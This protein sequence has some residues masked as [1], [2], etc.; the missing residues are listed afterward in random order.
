MRSIA[1]NDSTSPRYGFSFSWEGSYGHVVE[2]V[3]RLGPERGVIIDLG[4]GVGS[5]AQPLLDLGY[6]YVGVDI[7]PVAL[8]ELSKRGLEGH[9]LDLCR[10]DELAKK[11]LDLA[12]GRR[13]ATVLLIDVLEHIPQT[14][15]FLAAIRAGLELLNRPPLVISVPN[16]AH[17]DL[18]AKLVFGKWDY[19]RTGLLDSTHMQFFTCDRLQSETRANGLLEL[20]AH[21]FKMRASDQHFP[22]D[23]PA[24][25]WTSPVAQAIRTWRE[26][27]DEHGETNQ[28][29]RAFAP[30]DIEPGQTPEIHPDV[31]ISTPLAVVMR[32]QGKRMS[33]LRDALTCLAAQTSDGFEVLLMVHT[34]DAQPVVGEVEALVSDFNPLFSSRVRVVHVS[35]GRRARPLNAALAR[36]KAEYVAFLD[37]DDL[38]MADWVE[39][40]V[41]AAGGGA[42]VRSGVA[43]REVSAPEESHCHPHVV[44]SALQFRYKLD[45][46]RLGHY[47]GNETPICSF[48]VPHSLIETLGLRFGEDLPV[49]EDWD[50]LMRCVAFASVRDTRKV[51]SIY[52]MWRSGESS[53]SLHE[54]DVWQATQRVLQDR[55]NLQSLILPPGSTD[56]LVRMCEQLVELDTLRLQLESARHEVATVRNNAQRDHE[57]IAAEVSAARDELQRI[58]SAYQM[59]INSRRWRILGPPARLIAVLRQAHLRLWSRARG[60]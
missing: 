24:L 36:V 4:C 13:V 32:T 42:I 10:T 23:H 59:T 54:V 7:D 52:Q 12:D 11:M 15:P 16:V 28:F 47:W 55:M 22:P 50:F 38:V 27:A 14:Q 48:A 43:V 17:S 39:S 56:R 40:F 60:Q 8:E 35:G 34:D 37:D 57:N 49:L 21:D 33:R 3:K 25:S 2:L 18:G 19:T 30:C 58:Q 53:A 6:E 20:G 41:K 46:D 9:E 1:S 45:F 44:Q 29:V 26:A 51:T 31:T 5:I